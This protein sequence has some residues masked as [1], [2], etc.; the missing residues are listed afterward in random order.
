ME[1]FEDEKDRQI[2]EKTGSDNELFVT[3]AVRLTV[4]EAVDQQPAEPGDAGGS[5]Q[6]Q[7]QMK[8]MTYAMPVIF[9]FVLY[10]VSSGL[11]LYWTMTNILSIGQQ[12]YINHRQKV[13]A[14]AKA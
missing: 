3:P 11:L 13:K 7:S 8:M 14:K 1:I 6:Q 12:L 2:A 4:V 10:D 9:L 5:S